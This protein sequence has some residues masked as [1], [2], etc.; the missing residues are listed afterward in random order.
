M[1]FFLPLHSPQ[2]P[3][4]FSSQGHNW[5]A[6]ASTSWRSGPWRAIKVQ[7]CFWPPFR[8]VS[9][10][11]AASTCAHTRRAGERAHACTRLSGRPALV[12]HYLCHWFLAASLNFLNGFADYRL[13]RAPPSPRTHTVR[14]WAWNFRGVDLGNGWAAFLPFFSHRKKCLEITFW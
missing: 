3:A 6:I 7:E 12:L 2:S 5:V 8:V 4:G 11:C 14:N 9:G 1:K 13:W 10:D